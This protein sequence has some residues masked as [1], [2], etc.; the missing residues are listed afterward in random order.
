MVYVPQRPNR[1]LPPPH[2]LAGR[3]LENK[4][5]LKADEFIKNFMTPFYGWGS[6]ALR[7]RSHYKETVYFLAL[8]PQQFLILRSE[9]KN[10]EIPRTDIY[11]R[12]P[13]RLQS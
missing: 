3:K 8:S 12:E 4:R 13:K 2:I 10:G 5:F 7:L 11:L 6:T 1:P 9:R